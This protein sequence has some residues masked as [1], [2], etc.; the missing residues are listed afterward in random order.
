MQWVGDKVNL[1]MGDRTLLF[2]LDPLNGLCDILAGP[3]RQVPHMDPGQAATGQQPTEF[4]L[5]V[6]LH[7]QTEIFPLWEE[8]L[9]REWYSARR[10]L[11]QRV[12]YPDGRSTVLVLV[13]EVVWH[14]SQEMSVTQGA[15]LP[16]FLLVWVL[17]YIFL[18]FFI[19]I[20]NIKSTTRRWCFLLRY[21]RI[22]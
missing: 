21:Y 8:N 2:S 13:W 7:S 20:V 16:F 19:K 1:H 18:P 14:D 15:T 12:P 4:P 9:D 5:E 22:S 6:V 17:V 11:H 3:P 10:D